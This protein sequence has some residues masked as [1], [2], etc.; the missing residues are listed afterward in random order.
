MGLF[1][2]APRATEVRSQFPPSRLEEIVDAALNGGAALPAP[3]LQEILH[4][5]AA[6]AC[7]DVL[8]S[9]VR[10]LPIDSIMASAGRRVPVE[11]PQ[12]VTKPSPLTSRR[13][14]TGQ[15][16]F[17]LTTDGNGFGWVDLNKLDRLGM[18]T[19][20]DLLDPN[21]LPRGRR[22]IVDG[23]PQVELTG[24]DSAA[25]VHQLWP[26]GP[27]WHVPGKMVPPGTV[28]ALSPAD[29]AAGAIGAGLKAQEF[30]ARY[31][32]D[33]GHPD[34]I[35][36]S[37]EELDPA[38][39]TRIKEAFM[40]AIRPGRREP[41][42]LGSG[43]T[44]TQIQVDPNNTQFLE[45]IRFTVEQATRFWHVPP[46]MIYAQISGQNVNYQNVSQA[47]L[48]YLKH[49]IEDYLT[50]LEDSFELLTPT[51]MQHRF[52]RDAFLRADP[53]AR[54]EL[55]KL[56]LETKTRTPNEVRVIEDEPPFDGAEFDQPGIPSSAGELE[57]ARGVA[58]VL[59]KL[60]LAVV[61]DVISAEEGRG[62]AN[63]AGAQ[64]TG[65]APTPAAPAPQEDPDVAA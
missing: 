59:Q 26:W 21:R 18:P 45:L 17:S 37:D 22:E 48:H 42:V 49:S 11:S 62:I 36:S 1:R 47:D 15:V 7:I 44:Y 56:R 52:N 4:H 51:G 13:V 41:A 38:M 64:L 46:A 8:S 28:F 31:F 53:K 55:H 34:A 63:R 24:T 57:Q 9:T 32:H 58:E 19:S 3:T 25:G 30:A 43:I 60:Y 39:A 61:N 16:M 33:G 5:A 27:I 54:A 29:H 14:W 2:P 65:P 50:N 12:I 40:R 20:I 6:W 23:I 35:L 10:A